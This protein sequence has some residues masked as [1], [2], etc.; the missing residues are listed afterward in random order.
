MQPRL[1][2]ALLNPIIDGGPAGSCFLKRANRVGLS[3]GL[4]PKRNPG[5]PAA[6]QK[7]DTTQTGG[8]RVRV[9]RGLVALREGEEDPIKTVRRAPNRLSAQRES[10]GGVVVHMALSGGGLFLLET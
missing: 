7:Y 4:L 5:R 8:K 2:E 1:P 9:W 10:G 6:A 3:S